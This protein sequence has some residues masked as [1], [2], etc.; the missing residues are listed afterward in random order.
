[1]S[2]LLLS[3]AGVPDELV[4]ADYAASDPGVDGALG[5]LVRD[6]AGR[7]RAAALRRRV[8]ISPRATMLEVLAWLHETAGGPEAYLRHAGPHGRPAGAVARRGWSDA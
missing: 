1:M 8:S 7:D 2:A 3:L 5:A 6:G 4:A